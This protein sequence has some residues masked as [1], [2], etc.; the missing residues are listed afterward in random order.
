MCKT[1]KYE[2]DNMEAACEWLSW[3]TCESTDKLSRSQLSL[4]PK[5]LPVLELEVLSMCEGYTWEMV[6]M[7]VEDGITWDGGGESLGVGAIRD[8]T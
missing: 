6:G 3:R 5:W 4:K 7:G 8:I 1:H 2:L